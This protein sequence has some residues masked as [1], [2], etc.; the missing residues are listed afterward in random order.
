MTASENKTTLLE[1]ANIFVQQGSILKA[2]QA[3]YDLHEIDPNDIFVLNQLVAINL[4][5]KSYD[6]AIINLQKMILIEPGLVDSYDRLANTYAQVGDYPNA[7]RTYHALLLH[8]PKLAQ[9]HFNLAYYLKQ[10]AQFDES[11][12]SYKAALENGIEQAEEVYLNIAVIY[13][14]HL[15]KH[16]EAEKYLNMALEL[17]AEYIPALYNLA[18]LYED[19]GNKEKTLEYFEA[20][21]KIKPNHVKALARIAAFKKFID[22]E[23][24]H[25]KLLV[26]H[27]QDPEIALGDKIDAYYALGKAYNDCAEY[28]LSFQNYTLANQINSF[29]ML[30]YSPSATQKHFDNIISQYTKKWLKENSTNKSDAPIFICGMFR[31]GSTLIEQML[32]A[33]P[34][35]IAGGERDFFSRE[36]H[37]LGSFLPDDISKKNISYFN[38]ANSY[39]SET[40]ELFGDVKFVTDKR[41]DNFAYLGFIKTLFPNAKIIYTL[42]NSIDNCLSIYFAR[43]SSGQNYAVNLN[44][45]IHYN[46]QQLRLLEHW[47]SLFGD[48]M[49]IVKYEDLIDNPKENISTLL[50]YLNLN[51]HDDCLNFHELKNSVKTASVWQVR[52]PLY[53]K[54]SGRWKNFEKHIQPLISH[55]QS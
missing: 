22:K 54:S 20:I 31:S 27:A 35:I 48:D 17:N 32:A 10:N 24:E 53:K 46:D 13:T 1:Q 19:S 2:M 33:H 21:L 12:T 9:A 51:W 25:I 30:P 55:Y 50:K 8:R 36:I 26:L 14:D 7:C 42:R 43:L 34:E 37:K 29:E 5:L 4:Q 47:K 39:Q 15:Q 28:D 3:Y 16:D 6:Q 40:I 11:I 52:E 23:D 38:L 45:I 18:N 41:P 44:H 49:Q